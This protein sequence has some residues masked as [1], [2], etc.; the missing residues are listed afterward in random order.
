MFAIMI[1]GFTF[2]L[3]QKIDC[4]KVGGILVRGYSWKLECAQPRELK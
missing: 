2:T 3:K 4:D 1:A